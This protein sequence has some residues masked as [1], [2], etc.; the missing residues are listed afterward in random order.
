MMAALLDAARPG[1]NIIVGHM[2]CRFGMALV[3][4]AAD[5]YEAAMRDWLLVRRH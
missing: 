1:V 4:A 5:F 2:R 3:P